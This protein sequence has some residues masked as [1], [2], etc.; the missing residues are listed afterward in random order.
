MS[1]SLKEDKKYHIIYKTINVLTCKYYIGMHS[2]DNLEDGYLG[3]GKRLTYSIRKYGKEN[4]SREIL[5]FCNSRE[6][7]NSRESE[8]ITM[9][10]IAK[11][12]CMNLKLGGQYS[13]GMIGKTQSA[14]AKQKISNAHKDRVFTNEWKQKISNS[15]SGRSISSEHKEKI[16]KANIGNTNSFGVKRTDET[17]LKQSIAMKNNKIM[18][19]HCH[20]IG[21]TS[22][23]KRYHF[24]KCKKYK[25]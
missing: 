1:R 14:E 22:N 19:P 25:E 5:E 20:Q 6:E 24:D 10:E 9:N 13:S 21:G 17:K 3:S 8:I 15:L 2:T 11:K 18:C 23:M 7:L 12:E 4:H 16:R